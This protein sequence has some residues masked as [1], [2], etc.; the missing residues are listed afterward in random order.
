[1]N[2]QIAEEAAGWFVELNTGGAGH[3]ARR[4]FDD[5]LRQ[6]PEHVRQYLKLLPLW[7]DGARTLPSDSADPEQVIARALAAEPVP[8]NLVTLD[9]PHSRPRASSPRHY[10]FSGLAAAAA[11]VLVVGAVIAAFFWARPPVYATGIGERRAVTL[12]DGSTLELN[13]RSRVKVRFSGERRDIELL[14]GQALFNV[15]RDARRPFVVHSG[16]LKVRAVGTRFDVYRTDAATIVTV[17]EGRVAIPNGPVL[18]KDEQ[19]VLAPPESPMVSSV[20][21]GAITAWTQGRLVFDGMPLA[22]AVQEFNRYN[23]RR[24]VV[25]EHKLEDFKLSGSFGST[26][27]MALIEFLRVQPGLRVRETAA[28]IEIS[29]E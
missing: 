4:A 3:G 21:A 18:S 27:P 19:A 7:E 28:R 14:E 9:L 15:A 11:L 6:S 8:E 22:K 29:H 1:M 20:D 10:R 17:L 23:V 12:A 2:R 5:W 25:L 16:D 13:T 24:M 26:D